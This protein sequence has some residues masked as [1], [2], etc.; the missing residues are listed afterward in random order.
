MENTHVC[1]IVG[2]S[3]FYED[4]D[5][6]EGDL[7]IAADGGYDRLLKKGISPSVIIGD[8]DSVKEVPDGVETVRFPIEKDETDTHLAY[9]L[10]YER[11]YRNFMI[12]GGTGGRLDHTLANLSLL[13]HIKLDG[14]D[15]RLIGSG[16]EMRV[17]KDETVTLCGRDGGDVSVFAIG[18]RAE[19]VCI[20]GLK[21]EAD[22]VTLEESF[23]L[24]V[25]NSFTESGAGR[26]S[27]KSGSLL[28]MTEFI[29]EN[30]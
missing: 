4:L 13:L 19:G 21:Y 1:Y 6:K 2:A 7:V 3:D 23:A 27:V 24:G 25:S 9:L 5:V 12:F 8:M 11:G 26:I 14:A 18:G 29:S 15:A 10:G 20:E 30:A 22:N 16:Y 17:I 28:V